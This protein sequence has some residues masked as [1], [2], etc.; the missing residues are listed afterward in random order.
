M[1][2]WFELSICAGCSF[3]GIFLTDRLS[4]LLSKWR[5]GTMQRVDALCRLHRHFNIDFV[6]RRLRLSWLVTC[7]QLVDGTGD[8]IWLHAEKPHTRLL[9]VIC[10][11]QKETVHQL[12][13]VKLH[14]NLMH[15]FCDYLTVGSE[16][17]S[18]VTVWAS[19][20]RGLSTSFCLFLLDSATQR[21]GKYSVSQSVNSSSMREQ[22]CIKIGRLMHYT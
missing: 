21:T 14:R 6:M 7:N 4:R 16:E 3:K 19:S 2:S 20:G 10:D 22:D 13:E 5:S 18:S 8:A 1:N 15:A 17:V 12:P 9:P 11:C